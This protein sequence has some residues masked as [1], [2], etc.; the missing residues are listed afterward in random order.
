MSSSENGGMQTDQTRL[1]EE[2]TQA[3]RHA[4][5]STPIQT[6]LTTDLF[7]WQNLSLRANYSAKR[8][9]ERERKREKGRE[10]KKEREREKKREKERERFKQRGH[11]EPDK[12]CQ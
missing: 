6:K 10:R 4:A 3:H 5:I 12:Q 2:T 1:C 9:R 7:M 8:E 11:R